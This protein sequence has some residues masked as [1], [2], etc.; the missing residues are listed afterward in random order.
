MEVRN[1][2]K[3]EP[4]VNGRV[5]VSVVC[6]LEIAGGQVYAIDFDQMDYA[7]IDAQRMVGRPVRDRAKFP[8]WP[9]PEPEAA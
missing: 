9:N 7:V 2:P 6:T 4:G 5:T 1:P 8:N 3:A